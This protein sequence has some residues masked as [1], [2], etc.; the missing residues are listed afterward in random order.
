MWAKVDDLFF[1]HP[2][3]VATS[4]AAR[5][6]WITAL[7]WTSAVKGDGWI[8]DAILPTLVQEDPDLLIQELLHAGLWE[9]GD[10]GYSV[11]DYLD[12]NPSRETLEERR[13]AA[14]ARLI[15]HRDEKRK[16]NALHARSCNGVK[17]APVPSRPVP[18]PE[19]SLSLRSREGGMGGVARKRALARTWPEDFTLTQ[20]RAEW[21]RDLGVDA[22]REWNKFRDN[23]LAKGLK[24]IDWNAAW[25]TWIRRAPDFQRQRGG[26]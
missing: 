14:N 15:R 24:Y 8:P 2:K 12:W 16:R 1:C 21:A 11:H 19:G 23:C 26:G 7:A 9:R 13:N 10:H 3:V 25:R 17:Q 20:E 5:G 18:G 6:L 4:L 22:T